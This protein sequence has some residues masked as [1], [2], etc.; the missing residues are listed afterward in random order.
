MTN[1]VDLL[2]EA[3]DNAFMIAVDI[4][5]LPESNQLQLMREDFT[6][7]CWKMN[8]PAEEHFKIISHL[9]NPSDD[10][11]IHSMVLVSPLF[12]AELGKQ[13]PEAG[14]IINIKPIWIRMKEAG[15]TAEIYNP[16]KRERL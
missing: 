3:F 2:N 6:L 10:K 15:L 9:P 7:A 1:S 13:E 11:H 16:L 12:L 5:M 8:L 4:D 14:P